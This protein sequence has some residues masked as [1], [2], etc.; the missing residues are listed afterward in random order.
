[1]RQLLSAG[2]NTLPVGKRPIILNWILAELE[3]KTITHICACLDFLNIVDLAQDK[4][5]TFS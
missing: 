4:L 1:M 2:P 5:M 3:K